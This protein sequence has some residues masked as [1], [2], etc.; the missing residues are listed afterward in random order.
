MTEREAYIALNMMER[1]GPVGVRQLAGALGSVAAILEADDATLARACGG[2]RDL[3]EALRAGRMDADWRGQIARAEAEGGRLLAVTDEEYPDAL[4]KI[5]DPP[6]ALYVRG[7]LTSRDRHAIAIVG[8]R[9]PSQYG[10]DMARTLGRDLAR[11]GFTV[12][13]G[14]AEGIDTAAH[15]GALEGGGRTLAVIAGGLDCLYPASNRELAVRIAG[16]GAILTEYPFGRAPDRS[17]FPVRNRIISGLSLGV[18]V[19]EAGLKSGSLHTVTQALDQGRT[20]FAVPGRV[21]AS[22]ARGPHSL[23]K[24]GAVLVEDATDVVR[25]FETLLPRAAGTLAALEAARQAPTPLALT[26][27]EQR[28]W[29]ALADGEMDVDALARQCGLSA[30]SVGATLIGMEMKRLV[31][32]LPGR[33]VGRARA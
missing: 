23:I 29:T 28:I 21:D 3:A 6:M 12:V 25:E 24:N 18:I 32:M 17:T 9:H 13:S 16:Q 30:A 7:G 19:V 22:V 15:L 4:G 10:R 20:V 8:T 1:V 2:R 31:R 33:L 5:H 26:A 14:L 11:A 27:E